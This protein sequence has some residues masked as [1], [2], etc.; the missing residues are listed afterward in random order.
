M[1]NEHPRSTS[2]RTLPTREK[3]LG[4]DTLTR[5]A[6]EEIL[7]NGWKGKGGLYR[8]DLSAQVKRR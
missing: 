6:P 5:I 1:T 8:R 3:T 7:F 4:A 2:V